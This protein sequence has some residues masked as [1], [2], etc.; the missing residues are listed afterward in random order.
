M[1]ARPEV[2][3]D[4]GWFKADFNTDSGR[5]LKIVKGTE[6]FETLGSY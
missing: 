6:N 1:T 3:F 2:K 4:E 5:V